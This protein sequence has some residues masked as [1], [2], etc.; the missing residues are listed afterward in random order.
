MSNDLYLYTGDGIVIHN[1]SIEYGDLFKFVD[2]DFILHVK[3]NVL[4]STNHIS[5][6]VKYSEK[7]LNNLITSINIILESL[8]NAFTVLDVYKNIGLPPKGSYIFITL[9]N[10]DNVII[11][12]GSVISDIQY[13]SSSLHTSITSFKFNNKVINQPFSIGHLYRS[14][15]NV[16]VF[17]E[18]YNH[19]SEQLIKYRNKYKVISELLTNF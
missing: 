18:M 3:S 11:P 8:N 19:Y 2:L 9:S 5:N 15:V 10:I 4:I 17:E 7:S 12:L 1:T 16:S 6:I 14:A 13:S